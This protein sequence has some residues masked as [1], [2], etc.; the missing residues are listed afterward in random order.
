MA[1]TR[2]I[3][4][5]LEEKLLEHGHEVERFYLPFIETPHDMLDQ[6]AALR[7][8]DLTQAGDRLI[9][10]RPPAYVLRHPNKVLWFI[11]HIRAYYDLSGS[12]SFA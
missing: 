12:A 1:A 5:W 2:F 4:E 8:M 10:F 11:H 7:M 9:A 3:V 6:I